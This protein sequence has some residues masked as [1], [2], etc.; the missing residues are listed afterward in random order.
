M[1]RG[2]ALR[3]Q[4][5]SSINRNCAHHIVT[6]EDPIEFV[7]TDRQ[8]VINSVKLALTH[9]LRTPCAPPA[10]R[11]RRH[12]RRRAARQADRG[13]GLNA[14]EL[15]TLLSTLHTDAAE[16]INRLVGFFPRHQR[17]IRAQLERTAR[18]ALPARFRPRTGPC[19]GSRI[20]RNNGVI[21]DCIMDPADRN[22]P[23]SW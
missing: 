21:T 2:R 18:H 19:R 16:T 15:V 13:G 14:A 22:I 4:R 12:P 10:P 11:P 17:Q 20:M 9:F 23:T 5:W 6:I 7:F 3:W 1:V 8:S